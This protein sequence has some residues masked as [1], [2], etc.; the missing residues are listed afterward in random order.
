MMKKLSLIIATLILSSTFLTSQVQ[1]QDGEEIAG[2]KL[3]V[4]LQVAYWSKYLDKG[5][6][7][8]GDKSAILPKIDLDFWGTGFGFETELRRANSSGFE[9]SERID[10]K[11][12]FKNSLFDDTSCKTE[13]KFSA[14]YHNHP[15]NAKKADDTY[16]LE[17]SLAWPKFLPWGLVPSYATSYETP[18]KG[19]Y[20]NRENAG[21]VHFFGLGYDLTIPELKNQTFHLSTTIVYN[22]GQGSP[23]RHEDW[24]HM[25]FGVATDLPLAKNITLS[26]AIYYQSSWEDSINENNELYGAITVKFKF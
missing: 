9:N 23:T 2:K 19:S 13:Y 25:N 10:F 26:P 8:Y 21:W 5:R 15:D 3:G 6:E 7:Y 22:D 1:G 4:T 11:P 16:E 24:S 18:V 17:M 12:Y 20:N 14:A